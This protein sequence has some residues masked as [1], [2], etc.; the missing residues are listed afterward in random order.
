[1]RQMGCSFILCIDFTEVN[2]L[3]KFRNLTFL[4]AAAG[5]LTLI[6][7]G[8]TAVSGAYDGI[9]MCI[10]TVIPSI[11]PFM[12]L[13]QLLTACAAP[14]SL[15]FITGALKLPAGSGALAASSFLGG[16]PIGAQSIHTAWKSGQLDMPSA[17]RMLYFCNNPGPSFIFGIVAAQF[18]SPSY[19]WLIWLIL[20]LGAFSV[21]A[22]APEADHSVKSP[23]NNPSV[24]LSAALSSSVKAMGH[25]CG[26]A[27]L[28]RV[29]LAFLRKWFLWLVSPQWQV[30][31]TGVLELT[32]GCCILHAVEDVGQRL[33]I[34]CALLSFGGLCVH[35][36]TAS[37][38]E[39]LDVKPCIIG[40]LMHCYFSTIYSVLAT[41]LLE[42]KMDEM[43][44]IGCIFLLPPFIIFRKIKIT[45][46]KPVKSVV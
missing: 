10:R 31:I 46:S 21:I 24:T 13:S 41:R 16:Y 5:M 14:D 6:F 15:N 30:I 2:R 39:G 28:F 19:G 25:I 29:I 27:V 23:V 7:D 36:Q 26:W 32:N 37:V 43:L 9:Q 11:F 44:I 38:L 17:R 34:S 3:N 35:M 12:I 42:R 20:L 8:K 33:V 45:G 1:M 22:I 18:P 4:F 40:K